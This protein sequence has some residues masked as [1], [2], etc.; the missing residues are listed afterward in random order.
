MLNYFRRCSKIILSLEKWSPFSI[1]L[2]S[3]L[4]YAGDCREICS[5]ANRLQAIHKYKYAD[6]RIF[7]KSYMWLK[8]YLL[9]GVLKIDNWIREWGSETTEPYGLEVHHLNE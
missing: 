2:A 4:L 5:L 6:Q 7:F 8:G 9:V 1:S 3:G